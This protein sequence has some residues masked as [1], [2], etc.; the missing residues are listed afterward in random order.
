MTDQEY[1]NLILSN[2]PNASEN[3]INSALG[4]KKI[5]DT[6][7]EDLRDKVK[8]LEEKINQLEKL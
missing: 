7:T 1:I 6:V 4:L 3:E 5:V 8:V 2:K